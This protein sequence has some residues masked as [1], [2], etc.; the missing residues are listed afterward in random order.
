M[1]LR[2][3]STTGVLDWEAIYDTGAPTYFKGVCKD[4]DGNIYVA[5]HNST[6]VHFAKYDSSGVQE[7]KK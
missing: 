7:W 4:F 1:L 2:Y 3:N 6:S 5:G